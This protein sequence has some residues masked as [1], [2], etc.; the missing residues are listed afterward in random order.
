MSFTVVVMARSVTVTKRFSISSGATPGKLQITL[1]TGILMLGK[2]SVAIR[3]IVTIPM[4]TIRMAIT[5]KVYGRRSA[6][7][8]I[9]MARYAWLSE[10]KTDSAARREL[11]AGFKCETIVSLLVV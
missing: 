1:T 6:S 8:T 11:I 3:V 4:S 10:A 2:M 7:R 9:H 5:V